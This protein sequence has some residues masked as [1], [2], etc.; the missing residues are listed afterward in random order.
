MTRRGTLPDKQ[1]SF[2]K[3]FSIDG[4]RMIF[5]VV[6]DIHLDELFYPSIQVPSRLTPLMIRS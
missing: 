3:I 2:E 5:W 4:V 6:Q 1:G